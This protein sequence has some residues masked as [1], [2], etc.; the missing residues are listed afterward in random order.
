MGLVAEFNHVADGSLCPA[1]LMKP[2]YELRT[3]K[4]AAQGSSLKTHSDVPGG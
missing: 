1:Y 4:L 3:L 2:Q